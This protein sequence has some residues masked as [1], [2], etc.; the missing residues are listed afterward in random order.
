MFFKN[1]L[2]GN[3]KQS[4]LILFEILTSKCSFIERKQ[5]CFIIL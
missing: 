2:T 4:V 3:K 5:G 1:F